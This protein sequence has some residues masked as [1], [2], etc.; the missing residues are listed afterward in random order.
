MSVLSGGSNGLM[1]DL[2]PEQDSSDFDDEEDEDEVKSLA[3]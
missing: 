3:S 1:T 2:I